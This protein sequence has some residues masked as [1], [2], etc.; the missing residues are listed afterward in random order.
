MLEDEVAGQGVFVSNFTHS[1]DPKKRLTIPSEWRAQIGTPRSLYILP[2]V[3]QR[4]LRCFPAAE[5]MRRIERLRQHAISDPRAR[6]FA[7]VLAAQ[8]DLVSWDAQGRIRIKNELLEY[9]GLVDQVKLVGAFETFELWAPEAL[10]SAG[11]MDPDS[12]R[13]AAKYVGF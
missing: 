7:R 6:Q 12:V 10:K 8:S 9:A 4:C 11:G 3:N 5:M 1:L 13:E 2:D